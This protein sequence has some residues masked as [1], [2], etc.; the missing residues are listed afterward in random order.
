MCHVMSIKNI[1]HPFLF[2][3]KRRKEMLP[4]KRDLILK[5]GKFHHMNRKE[6]ISLGL[7]TQN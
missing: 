5:F 7:S 2:L 4:E 3:P 1:Q 6:K